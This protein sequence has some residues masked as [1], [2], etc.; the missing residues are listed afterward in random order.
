MN[1]GEYSLSGVFVSCD[2]AL[3]AMSNLKMSVWPSRCE[4]SYIVPPSGENE[5]WLSY[6]GLMV[7]FT[8]VPTVGERIVPAKGTSQMSVA[9]GSER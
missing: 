2:E 1:C 6:P 3:L 5:G 4:V 9:L 7:T 8:V